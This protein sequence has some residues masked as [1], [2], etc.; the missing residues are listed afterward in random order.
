[1]ESA[2]VEGLR[3]LTDSRMK[4]RGKHPF[5]GTI[6]SSFDNTMAPSVPY[7]LR[8]PGQKYA[9]HHDEQDHP[10]ADPAHLVSSGCY[11][12]LRRCHR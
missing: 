11:G 2:I 12:L 7:G 3:K 8:N 4:R 1:M 10:N 9:Q 6:V 5:Q